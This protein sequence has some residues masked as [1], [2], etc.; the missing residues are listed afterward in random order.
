MA[1]L[2]HLIAVRVIGGNQISVNIFDFYNEWSGR[3][4]NLIRHWPS[5]IRPGCN[6]IFPPK[7]NCRRID[8]AALC[9]GCKVWMSQSYQADQ[10]AI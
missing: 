6:A 3:F 1:P 8:C 10:Y 5:L 9:S 2:V 7:S 4:G